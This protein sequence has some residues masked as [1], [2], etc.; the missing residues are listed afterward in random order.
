MPYLMIGIIIFIIIVFL[1]TPTGKGIVGELQVRLVLGKNKANEKY[2]INNLM[3]V[4]DGKSSQIDHVLINRNGVFVIETKNYSGRIYGSEDQREWT[5]VLSYGKV[6]N[7]FY[8]PILQN[9]THIYTLSKAI[10]RSDCFISIIV[11]PKAELKTSTI[12]AVGHL[13][14]IKRRCKEQQKDIF[15]VEEM[16]D[17]YKRLMEYKNN[18]SVSNAEHIHEIKQMLKGTDEN[19]CPRCGKELVERKGR[20][21]TFYACSGFPKCKFKKFK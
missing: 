6:K 13:S 14:S 9:R 5:Q 18:P 8:N 2:V 10:G 20:Y 21:G 3:I 16:N 17:I 15:T 7:K 1:K 4:T 11:F 12:T 19:I